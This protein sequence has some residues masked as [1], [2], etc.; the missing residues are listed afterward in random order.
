M[1][2]G[3]R[4]SDAGGQRLDVRGWILYNYYL[5]EPRTQAEGAGVLHRIGS[6][7]ASNKRSKAF[8]NLSQA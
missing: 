5:L 6:Y 4:W 1:N 7:T 2:Q 3:G 8:K